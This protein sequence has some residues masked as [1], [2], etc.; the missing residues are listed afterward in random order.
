MRWTSFLVVTISD[1]IKH[2]F[3]FLFHVF[4]SDDSNVIAQAEDPAKELRT[5]CNGD[6]HF[7]V[8]LIHFLDVTQLTKLINDGIHH[9]IAETHSD[10]LNVAAIHAE[11]VSLILSNIKSSKDVFSFAY[12][13]LLST[14]VCH[15][16]NAIVHDFALFRIVSQEIVI[17]IAVNKSEWTDNRLICDRICDKSPLKTDEVIGIN[18]KRAR[19]SQD[20]PLKN[21]T[22][23]QKRNTPAFSTE[24]FQLELM[25][26]FE[27]VT[28]SLPKLK[29]DYKNIH[30]YQSDMGFDRRFFYVLEASSAK[31]SFSHFSGNLIS[32]LSRSSFLHIKLEFY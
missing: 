21:L 1:A 29:F 32:R 23:T 12:H 5:D 16:V 8:I 6:G 2:L 11:S 26:G 27:P 30:V 22:I 24:V 18:T 7:K 9:V 25:T 14:D 20:E 15:A 4:R 10:T 13:T 19:P 31:P 3:H 28:S 17:V